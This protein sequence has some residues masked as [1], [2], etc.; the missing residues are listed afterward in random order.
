MNATASDTVTIR[1]HDCGRTH[2]AHGARFL[3]FMRRAGW[4]YR[5]L[6]ADK[7]QH[8][9]VNACPECVKEGDW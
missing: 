3:H 6:G 7:V 2:E 4:R 9:I 8:Q 1:C 5:Q